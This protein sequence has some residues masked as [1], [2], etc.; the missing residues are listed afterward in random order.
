MSDAALRRNPL[1]GLR[2]LDLGQIYNGPYAGFLLA[3][4]GA[5]V[6]KVEPPGGEAI[7][8]RSGP[9]DVAFAMGMLNSS[10]R[11]LALDLKA[12]RGKALFLDLVAQA[13][14]IE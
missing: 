3:M 13:D 5:D 1:E 14:V 8:A 9:A 10:K 7:R 11:G 6:V 12:P 4:A 2:V